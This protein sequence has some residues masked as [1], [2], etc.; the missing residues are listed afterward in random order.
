M[1][2]EITLRTYLIGQALS[3]LL[4][5]GGGAK[6]EGET[7]ARAIVMAD[8]VV[9]HLHAHPPVEQWRVPAPK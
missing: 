9:A 6:S 4:A 1:N 8:A 3:G 5:H 7:A 2:E